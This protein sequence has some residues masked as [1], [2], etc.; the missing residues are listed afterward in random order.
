MYVIV[1][2]FTKR[3][4]KLLKTHL[5]S[6]FQKHILLL[7]NKMTGSH[8]NLVKEGNDLIRYATVSAVAIGKILKKYDKVCHYSLV[9]WHVWRRLYMFSYGIHSVIFFGLVLLVLAR[10]K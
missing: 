2:F 5:A 1:S 6:G 9:L 8:V 3:A 10:H 4:K 7:K